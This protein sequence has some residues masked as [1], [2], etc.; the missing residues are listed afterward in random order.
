MSSFT[1]RLL[2]LGRQLPPRWVGGE[3]FVGGGISQNPPIL[4]SPTSHHID[5]ILT[6]HWPLWEAWREIQMISVLALCIFCGDRLSI[7]AD[8]NRYNRTICCLTTDHSLSCWFKSY[9]LH[10]RKIVK[11]EFGRLICKSLESWGE[12]RDSGNQ[13]WQ[14]QEAIWGVVAG[15]KIK[16]TLLFVANVLGYVAFSVS[17]VHRWKSKMSHRPTQIKVFW[18]LH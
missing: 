7:F 1:A 16:Q 2:L 6:P 3:D 11:R 5:I 10:C 17:F 4:S 14:S 15:A 9:G 18:L 13:G 8:I 12:M